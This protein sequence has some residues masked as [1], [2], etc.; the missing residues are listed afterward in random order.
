MVGSS[1]PIGKIDLRYPI[2]AGYV[3]EEESGG[4]A[5]AVPSIYRTMAGQFALNAVHSRDSAIVRNLRPASCAFPG[6]VI[7]TGAGVSAESGIDTFRG[8]GGLWEQH[9]VDTLC[10]VRSKTSN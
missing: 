9:R 3:V 6:I 7:L 10:R 4:A 8:G 1:P 5:Y 2:R